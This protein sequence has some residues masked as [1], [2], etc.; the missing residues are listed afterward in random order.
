VGEH[1]EEVL[2]KLLGYSEEEIAKLYADDVIGS[3][4]HYDTVPR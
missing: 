3:W 4:D 1:N 2:G